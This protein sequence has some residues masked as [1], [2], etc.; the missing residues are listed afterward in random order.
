MRS[1]SLLQLINPVIG[2]GSL[3]RST[4]ESAGEGS[5]RF[6]TADT[7]ELVKHWIRR[8]GL[9]EGAL[10]RA[11]DRGDAVGDRLSDRG[12]AR[13]FQRLAKP[14]RRVRRAS[15]RFWEWS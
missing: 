15:V 11:I 2:C 12:V 8:A 14:W 13:A 6:L 5:I 7:V 4:C 1:D 9:T 3:L 10:F